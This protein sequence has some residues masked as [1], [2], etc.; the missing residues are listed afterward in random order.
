MSRSWG[1]I[2]LNVFK[3]GNHTQQRG[4]SAA[5]GANEHHELAVFDVEIDIPGDFH[6]VK[7]FTDAA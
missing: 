4:L 7:G 5:G 2:S 6:S 1:G 3:P